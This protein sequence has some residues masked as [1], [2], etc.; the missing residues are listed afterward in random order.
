MDKYKEIYENLSEEMKEKVRSCKT[1]DELV[2]FVQTEGIELTDE[3]L[4]EISG[5]SVWSDIQDSLNEFGWF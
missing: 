1:V 2:T 5:G 4:D 3:Q